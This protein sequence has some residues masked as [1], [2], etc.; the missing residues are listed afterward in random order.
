MIHGWVF[1]HISAF[2]RWP[3]RFRPSKPRSRPRPACEALGLEV[4]PVDEAMKAQFNIKGGLV[5]MECGR[6]FVP[7][8]RPERKRHN[9]RD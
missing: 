4:M 5:V 3:G 9:K 1:G 7:R 6:E 8:G 2:V